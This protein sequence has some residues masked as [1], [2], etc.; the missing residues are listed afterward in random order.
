MIFVHKITLSSHLLG[1]EAFVGLLQALVVSGCFF[2]LLPLLCLCCLCHRAV[3][4]QL[5]Y[6]LTLDFPLLT[7]WQSKFR[8]MFSLC[9]GMSSHLTFCHFWPSA[10]QAIIKL[11]VSFQNIA[12]SQSLMKTCRFLFLFIY[13]NLQLT[14]PSG[15]KLQS[16]FGNLKCITKL[17]DR[18][19]GI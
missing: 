7:G 2:S 9:L 11:K 14:H 12:L 8:F 1:R 6:A 10:K 13:A 3:I 4:H 19:S 18:R 17:S 15:R 16:L 5:A